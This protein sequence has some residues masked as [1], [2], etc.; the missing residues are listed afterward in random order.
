[1]LLRRKMNNIQTYK[2]QIKFKE[3]C[4]TIPSRMVFNVGY[5]QSNGKQDVFKFSAST[6]ELKL[7]RSKKYETII[8]RPQNSINSQIIKALIAYYAVSDV[9]SPIKDL[10]IHRVVG[11]KEEAYAECDAFQQPLLIERSVENKLHF[12]ATIISSIVEETPRGAALRIALSYWLNAMVE[13]NVYLIFENLWRAF[14]RLY[15]YQGNGQNEFNSMKTM[16]QLIIDNQDKFSQS[17]AITNGYKTEELHAFRWQ[18]MILNDFPTKN[19]TQALVEFV[20]RYSDKRIMALLNE[21]LVC[22]KVYINELGKWAEV[23]SHI[24]SNAHTTYDIELVTV[25]CIKYAYFIR[26]KYF[27]G[28][29]L[30]GTFKLMQNY[31]DLE[32]E[33]ISRLLATLIYEVINGNMLRN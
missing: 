13:D 27:H 4:T 18:Q 16:R 19:H 30:D 20:E 10:S 22:R 7:E 8:T 2:V 12:P 11:T 14:N 9:I 25:L 24:A 17:K 32:F 21:K 3:K 6:I 1:M 33:H 26:N 29:T 15:V 31:I 23:Q 28:E 5:K